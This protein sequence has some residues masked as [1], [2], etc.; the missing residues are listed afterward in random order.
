M[1][2]F[3]LNTHIGNIFSGNAQAGKHS[4]GRATQ[5]RGVK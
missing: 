1:H 4:G 2:L 5:E 3:L